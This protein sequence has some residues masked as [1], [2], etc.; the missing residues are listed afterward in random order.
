MGNESEWKPSGQLT[1]RPLQLLRENALILDGLEP[2]VRRRPE[3]L[4]ASPDHAMFLKQ[5]VS[6]L[7]FRVINPQ[8]N[9]V[10]E[11]EII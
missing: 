5:L 1:G 7:Y 4:L 11:G 10:Y 6:R 9:L 8:I 2:E 3:N